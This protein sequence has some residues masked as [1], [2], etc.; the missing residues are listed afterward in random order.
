MALRLN[1]G[2]RSAVTAGARAGAVLSAALAMVAPPAAAQS[3]RHAPAGSP[4]VIVDLSVL[5]RL[6]PSWGRSRILSLDP[7][8]SIGA[9]RSIAPNAGA[10]RIVL[11]P[12]R[13]ARIAIRRPAPRIR[14]PAVIA[15]RARPPNPALPEPSRIGTATAP[16]PRPKPARPASTPP[17]QPLRRA[18]IASPPPPAM[19]GPQG[20]GLAA[21]KEK[22]ARTPG[23]APTRIAAV[24]VKPMR[25]DEESKVPGS[26]SHYRLGFS[27]GASRIDKQAGRTLDRVVDG[28][29]SDGRLRLQLLAYAGGTG[30]TPRQSRRLSLSRALSVRSY[31]IDKGVRSTRIDVRALGNRYEDGPPDRVDVIVT[32]R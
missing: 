2:M 29:K 3:S 7:P 4:A 24:P 6:A 18:G 5:D 8:P 13:A 10:G 28:L 17:A 32:R 14:P 16:Q 30:N 22:A 1:L 25:G 21:A 20:P 26:S 27:S 15:P 23:P 12:P 31:L 11:K 9:A 19:A